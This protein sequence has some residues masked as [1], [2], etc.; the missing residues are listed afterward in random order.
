MPNRRREFGF[1]FQELEDNDRARDNLIN[2]SNVRSFGIGE[3]VL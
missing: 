1:L 3:E 2:I